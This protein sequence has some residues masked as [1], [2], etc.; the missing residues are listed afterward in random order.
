MGVSSARRAREEGM[1]EHLTFAIEG[2]VV[3]MFSS[4]KI[5]LVRIRLMGEISLLIDIEIDQIRDTRQANDFDT[6]LKSSRL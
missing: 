4:E 5:Q 3:S 6:I 1:G 2:K